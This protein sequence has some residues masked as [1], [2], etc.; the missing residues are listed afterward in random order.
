MNC[1]NS[2]SDPIENKFLPF[3]YNSFFLRAKIISRNKIGKAETVADLSSKELI[4]WIKRRPREESSSLLETLQ[5]IMKPK[6][7]ILGFARRKPIIMGILNITKDSFYKESK[8]LNNKEAIDYGIKLYEKGADIIDVGGESTRP[9]SIMIDPKIEEKR[10]TPIISALSKKG[11]CISCDTRNSNTMQS[12][13]NSGAK[14]INDISALSHCKN[15][16]EII[17]RSNVHVILMHKR[18]DPET[19]QNNVKYLCAPLDVYDFFKSRILI[20]IKSGISIEKII[21]DP[22]IGFGKLQTHNEEILKHLTMFKGLGCPVMI[23]VSRK[24]M[25]NKFSRSLDPKDQLPASLALVNYAFHKGAEIFRVHD[26]EESIQS[27]NVATNFG[28]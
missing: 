7:S 13:I 8:H 4:K 12:A 19:M 9:G 14:I 17:A 11:I 15:S 6:E 10:I 26:P 2:K 5:N 24:V 27:L 23:G 21:I 16:L 20:A 25:L 22:G 3:G 18:G 28:V 1:S